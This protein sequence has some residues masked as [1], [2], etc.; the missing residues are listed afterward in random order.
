MK[1]PYFF[2]LFTVANLAAFALFAHASSPLANPL[3]NWLSFSFGLALHALAGIAVRASI[4]KLRGDRT[5]VAIIR[6][7]AWLLDT[8]RL[9][10]AGGLVVVTYGWIK[11]V[12]PVYHP[13]RF[14]QQLWDLDQTLGLGFSPNILLLDL[15]GR[16]LFLHAIDWLYANVFFVSSMIAFAYFLSEPSRRVRIAFAN[17][18][19]VL[20]IA[21]AWLYLLVPSVGPAYGFPD[22]WLAHEA[23]LQRTQNFQALLMR[24]YQNVLRAASG[25]RPT[26]P[27]RIIFGIGA[28]PSL[29]VAFQTYVFF[30][31]RRIW[32]SGEVL[33]AL[34]VVTIFIGSMVTGWHYMIDGLAGAALAFACYACA[35]RA[36]RLSRWQQLRH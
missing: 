21:G 7:P 35:W 14:D 23:A 29:H 32:T 17:G 19:A 24:N 15:F 18:N 5:Y 1:R 10:L 4:A 9:V 6:K 25:Q 16:P 20:W 3:L 34:F 36:A 33:F 31:M 27:V 11:L 26:A 13:T 2:E 8:L 28:F 12:V 22:L 30:W